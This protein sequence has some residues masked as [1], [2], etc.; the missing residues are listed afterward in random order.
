[1]GL[2]GTS[3]D[4]VRSAEVVSLRFSCGRRL[5][6]TWQAHKLLGEA[7][8]EAP[9]GQSLVVGN[10]AGSLQIYGDVVRGWSPTE[11]AHRSGGCDFVAYCHPNRKRNK[12]KERSPPEGLP[13]PPPAGLPQTISVTRDLGPVQRL[14]AAPARRNRDRNR[15]SNRHR[16]TCKPR[17]GG[18]APGGRTA[19]A[20]GALL[21]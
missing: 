16:A 9:W 14:R 19:V 6:R 21:A 11:T 20:S 2:A 5:R 7:V 15:R 10:G 1:M 8:W 13:P 4:L 3:C 18:E 17:K 12:K